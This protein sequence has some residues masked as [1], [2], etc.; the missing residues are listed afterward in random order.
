MTSFECVMARLVALLMVPLMLFI[1]VFDMKKPEST[2]I[3]FTAGL[4]KDY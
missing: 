4:E 1:W 2:D 3:K